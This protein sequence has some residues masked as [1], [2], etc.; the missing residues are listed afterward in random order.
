MH[1]TV[2]ITP[3]EQDFIPNPDYAVQQVAKAIVR[4]P[5][6]FTFSLSSIRNQEYIGK[7]KGSMHSARMLN[8]QYT[9]PIGYVRNLNRQTPSWEQQNCVVILIKSNYKVRV[10]TTHEIQTHLIP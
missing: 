6:G 3:T 10:E 4:M 2:T 8:I 1:V 9:I 5:Q 7:N